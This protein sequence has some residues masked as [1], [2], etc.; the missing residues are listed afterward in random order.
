MKARTILIRMAL[1]YAYDW[2]KIYKALHSYNNEGVESPEVTKKYMALKRKGTKF[3]T[4][5]D[6][7]YPE[8]FK[9][10]YKPPFVIQYTGDISILN[11]AIVDK[12][13]SYL[14]GN[15]KF[16]LNEDKLITSK[17][18]I[19][20]FGNNKLNLFTDETVDILRLIPLIA[21]KLI[22]TK[23]IDKKKSFNFLVSSNLVVGK[24]VPVYIV[25]TIEP[26]VN[27]DI[28]VDYGGIL[29]DSKERLED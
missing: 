8:E 20:T 9:K 10:I 29:L 17:F 7:E 18:N 13:Y 5:L 26:S 11:K 2:D 28:I 22:C 14:Y 4:I 3:I 15:N 21:N 6:P 19:I 1:F 16:G 23:K 24:S 27:N 25:P 12:D